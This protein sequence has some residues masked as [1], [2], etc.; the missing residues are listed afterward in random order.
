MLFCCRFVSPAANPRALAIPSASCV[1]SA[2]SPSWAFFL[3][4]LSLDEGSTI[5]QTKPVRGV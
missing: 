1:S 3:A 2:G 5:G 4:A